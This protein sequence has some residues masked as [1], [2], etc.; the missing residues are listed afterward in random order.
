MFTFLFAASAPNEAWARSVI[1]LV[2]V[3][4]LVLALWTSG[5]SGDIRVGFG[6]ASVGV[7]AA[8]HADGHDI[9]R[10]EGRE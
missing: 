8:A 4:T 6:L 9:A 10:E 3:A 5:L 7:A 1:V 2:E